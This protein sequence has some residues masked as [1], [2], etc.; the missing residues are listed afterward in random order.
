[1]K[2]SNFLSVL[3]AGVF[4]TVIG[5]S[6]VYCQNYRANYFTS[7]KPSIALPA[8]FDVGSL[9]E[10]EKETWDNLLEDL[11]FTD[12]FCEENE[13]FWYPTYFFK[14]TEEELMNWLEENYDLVY[15]QD[16]FIVWQEF[17]EEERLCAIHLDS[18][19]YEER[20]YGEEDNPFFEEPNKLWEVERYFFKRVNGYLIPDK[21]IYIS[22]EEVDIEDEE[23]FEFLSGVICALTMTYSYPYYELM[24]EDDNNKTLVKT[25]D[26]ELYNDCMGY[27]GVKEI[28]QTA[29]KIYPNPAKEQI[30]VSMPFNGNENVD[31]KIFNMLGVNVLSQQAAGEQ[32]N[33]D[34]R[35]LPAGVYIVRCGKSDKVTTMRFVKQ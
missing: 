7:G 31:I 4:L 23:G 35:S 2:K 24:D 10:E 11:N 18:L 22:Y 12:D 33:V 9:T 3:L 34:V 16:G 19:I 17:E 13:H 20:W 6:K 29:L 25:G 21:D 8:S 14:A 1:M 27:T 32:I 28:Q 26:E 30:T 15:K 5:T